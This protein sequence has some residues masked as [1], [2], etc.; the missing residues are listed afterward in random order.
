M[1]KCGNF[2]VFKCYEMLL[3]QWE[4]TNRMVHT[5]S[6]RYV[7]NTWVYVA[8]KQLFCVVQCKRYAIKCNVTGDFGALRKWMIGKIHDV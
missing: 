8:A 1:P 2:K 4:L 3:P 7:R 5:K 6:H